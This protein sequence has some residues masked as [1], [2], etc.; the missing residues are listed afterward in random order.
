MIICGMK[1]LNTN[2][3]S[4][5]SVY[6]TETCCYSNE[7]RSLVSP[8]PLLLLCFPFSL[9]LT[10]AAAGVSAITL[11]SLSTTPCFSYASKRWFTIVSCFPFWNIAPI[12]HLLWPD[13]TC[14]PFAAEPSRFFLTSYWSFFK[15][16]VNL[17]ELFSLLFFFKDALCWSNWAQVS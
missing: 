12:V 3:Y 14:C 11:S 16:P 15:T 6:C 13:L 5:S 4:Y 2:R 17:L 9:S 1:E 7:M 8:F 10:L